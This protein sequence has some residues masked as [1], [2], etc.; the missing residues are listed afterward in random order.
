MKEEIPK[1]HFF[2]VSNHL[3]GAQTLDIDW[4]Q[5]KRWVKGTEVFASS[6]GPVG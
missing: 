4:P 3:A 5:T 6:A 2:E 1:S